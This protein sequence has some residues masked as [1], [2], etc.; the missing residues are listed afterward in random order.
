MLHFA[1]YFTARLAT[2]RFATNLLV[3]LFASDKNR[4]LY[5]VSRYYLWL[6][7]LPPIADSL[8]N[9]RNHALLNAHQ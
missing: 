3:P 1:V 6:Y 5:T 2:E 7:K 4:A 9:G 8:Y